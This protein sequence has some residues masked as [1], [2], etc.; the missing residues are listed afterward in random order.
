MC[1]LNN[2]IKVFRSFKLGLFYL[3]LFSM[4]KSFGGR[5]NTRELK[6]IVSNNAGMGCSYVLLVRAVD[7]DDQAP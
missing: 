1:V 6:C 5:V 2:L 7:F 4:R 3:T